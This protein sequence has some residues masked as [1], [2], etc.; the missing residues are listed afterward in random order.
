[1]PNTT[2]KTIVKLLIEEDSQKIKQPKP[3]KDSK[4]SKSKKDSNKIKQP[5][6]KKDISHLLKMNKKRYYIDK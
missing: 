5:K 4:K 3:K 6:P 1:M 2:I